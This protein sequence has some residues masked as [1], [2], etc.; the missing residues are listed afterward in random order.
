MVS[1]IHE[2]S[3]EEDLL[4]KFASVG[5]VS[6]LHLNLDRRTGFVKGYALI[7]YP[8]LK[9]ATAAIL[10]F[11]GSELFGLKLKVDFAFKQASD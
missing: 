6:Q 7:E 8:T 11:N 1:G 10:K 9:D 2:E 5:P 4:D 3:K